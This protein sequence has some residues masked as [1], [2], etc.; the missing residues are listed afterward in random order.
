MSIQSLSQIHFETFQKKRKRFDSIIMNCYVFKYLYFKKFMVICKNMFGIHLY[1]LFARN[2]TALNSCNIN[3]R[4]A[5]IF[6][7]IKKNFFW[8]FN[9][10][11]EK[12][13]P[14]VSPTGM[15]TVKQQQLQP[16]S[17]IIPFM[18]YYTNRD[19]IGTVVFMG[20]IG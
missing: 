7:K 14:V 1:L 17:D 19:G 5:N 3:R 16:P 8:N 13:K 18:Q 4:I 11:Y 15:C 6:W 9:N 12:T 2:W 10:N 20:A